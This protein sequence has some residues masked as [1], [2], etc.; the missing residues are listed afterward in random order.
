MNSPGSPNRSVP[1]NRRP[2]MPVLGDRKMLIIDTITTVEM[3]CG[4][5]VTVCTNPLIFDDEIWLISNASTI[6][7]MNPMTSV[8][9]LIRNVLTMMFTNMP[10]RKNCSKYRSPANLPPIRPSTGSKS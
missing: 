5:Y 2:I 8:H 4:I 6:G 1:G 7:A 3:K 10:D 9:R